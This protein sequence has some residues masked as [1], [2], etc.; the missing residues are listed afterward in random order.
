MD[1]YSYFFIAA[2]F[3]F[4]AGSFAYLFKRKKNA[5]IGESLINSK[6]LQL[7]AYERMLLLV[8]RI[9]LPNLVSRLNNSELSAKEMQLLLTQTIKQEYDYNI[10]QQ[11]YVSNDVWTVIKNLKEQNIYLI[12]QVAAMLPI[13][14]TAFDLNKKIVEFIGTDEKGKLNEAVSKVISFEAKKLL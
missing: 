14:A 13:T 3:I 8:D 6:Q 5:P 11:I 7:Q 10:T 1:N 9:A 2:L 12:N 4:L